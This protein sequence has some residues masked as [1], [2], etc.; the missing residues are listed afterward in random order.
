MPTIKDVA[1]K[2]NLSIATVS[3]VI[4]QRGAHSQKTVD[5]VKQAIEEL[6]YS[7]N[8][9]ARSLVKGKNYT[10]GIMLPGVGRPYWAQIAAAV[11]R[12]AD[13]RGYS[14][15]ITTAPSDPEEYIRKHQKLIGSFPDGIISSSVFG[16]DSYLAQAEVP[17]V[18]IGNTNAPH[19]IAS[20]DEQG[21]LLATRHLIAR[22]S[23]SLVHIGGELK[24][25]SSGNARSFAFIKEC[26][27]QGIPYRV[28]EA[29]VGRQTEIDCSGLIS[30]VFSSDMHFDGIFA[31]NDILAAD[32]LS[33]ALSLGYRV[34]QDIRIVG[35][36]D[37]QL[38]RLLYPQLT[39][40]RQ[41]YA[42]LAE[43]A[44]DSLIRLMDGEDIP[45]VQIVPVE[46]IERKTT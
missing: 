25:H 8:C 14:V 16:T 7:P 12:A 24:S 26:E 44:V 3:R 27:R 5:K 38:S 40:V 45:Q 21:G 31:S 6:N 15:M 9:I 11:E 18:I 39:T 1:Q 19:S 34:P 28:F 4:N 17:T 41:N 36:D 30:D 43:L 22:G 35:Y 32:C 23:R 10:L 13:Q 42:K 20:N 29:G 2:A 46:L 37:V 33:T